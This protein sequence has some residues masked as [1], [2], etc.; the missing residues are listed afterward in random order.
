MKKINIFD[1][2][3]ILFISL[4]LVLAGLFYFY[5]KEEVVGKPSLLTVRVYQN[6]D[7]IA[8]KVKQEKTVYFDSLDKSLEQVSV[9]EYPKYLDITI[10]GEG[11]LDDG[12]TIFEGQRVL[13]GQKA[14][15]HSS[16]FAQ[17]VITEIRYAD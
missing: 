1:V 15:I 8:P 2:L 10:K 12:R 6:H 13:V 4:F 7:D 9:K 14:E 16:Y 3:I 17:G 5:K 11:V